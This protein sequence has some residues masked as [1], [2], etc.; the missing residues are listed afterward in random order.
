MGFPAA[1]DLDTQVMIEYPIV[2]RNAI[3]EARRTWRLLRTVYAKVTQ[4]AGTEYRG[5]Q[6]VR[7]LKTTAFI[8]RYFDGLTEAMRLRC[9]KGVFQITGINEI[10]RREGF[11]VF[12][13]TVVDTNSYSTLPMVQLEASAGALT[14]AE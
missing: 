2:D 13:D 3:G 6:A 14:Y 7:S 12:A 10:G 4:T 8:M 9:S 1:G 5:A 11:E